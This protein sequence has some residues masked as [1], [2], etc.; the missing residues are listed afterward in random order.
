MS[1]SICSQQ[2]LPCPVPDH[3]QMVAKNSWHVGRRVCD[4]GKLVHVVSSDELLG[5]VVMVSNDEVHHSS[6]DVAEHAF[7][8]A[9]GHTAGTKGEVA[10]DLAMRS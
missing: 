4:F 7:Q 3:H 2:V 9:E 5:F 10:D 8:P 6:G 1:P